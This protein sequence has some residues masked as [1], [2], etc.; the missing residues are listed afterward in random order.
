MAIYRSIFVIF[1]SVILIIHASAQVD[2]TPTNTD[3]KKVVLVSQPD[4]AMK[5]TV[6]PDGRVLWAERKGTIML[7]H[8][9]TK[10]TVEAGRVPVYSTTDNGLQGIVRDPNFASN[11][12]IYLDYDLKDDSYAKGPGRWLSRF[13]LVGDVL[14]LST[15]KRLLHVEIERSL[16]AGC[17]HQAGALTFDPK[18]NIY[19][20]IGEE[21]DYSLLYANTSEANSYQSSFKTSANTN[22]LRG[23]IVRIHPEDNGTYTIPEGNLF[24]K[25]VAGLEKTRPE[26]Y[27]MGVRNAFTVKVDPKTGWLWVGEVAIDASEP[28]QEKGAPGY[29]EINLVTHAVHLGHPFV[30]GPN[31]PMR[32]YDYINN[33]P[34]EW[35]DPNHLVNNSKFN[36]GLIDLAPAG[37]PQPA[38]IYWTHLKKYST[39]F[40]DFGEGRMAGMVGPTYR[41]NASLT[42]ANKLPA[43]YDGKTFFYDYEREWIKLLTLTTDNKVGKIEPLMTDIPWSGLLDM[44]IGPDGAIYVIEYGH[45]FYTANPSAKIS[46]IDYVGKACGTVD[47]VEKSNEHLPNFK[48]TSLVYVGSRQILSI[49]LP[50]GSIGAELFSL[51]GLS[52]WNSKIWINSV[53]NNPSHGENRFEISS[54]LLRGNNMVLVRFLSGF[55]KE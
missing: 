12:W 31:D 54:E 44:E 1:S 46:R 17:C 10:T 30:N 27:V 9:D 26:I 25:G 42:S 23:K 14:D 16:M 41:F 48:Q 29:E 21:G 6:L 43:Y 2:C 53:R 8:P 35:F 22:D 3:F 19:W 5:L 28:S 33:K 32:N 20:A 24:P 36:T 51:Q 34:L 18:G 4:E 7:Y 11:H 45:G 47:A 50:E 49:A 39:A 37:K 40:P 13:T 55:N 52:L 38:L 15:E